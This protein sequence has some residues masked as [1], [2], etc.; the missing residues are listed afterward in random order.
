L[1]QIE[2]KAKS[3]YIDAVNKKKSDPAQAK[4]IAQTIVVMLPESAETHQKAKQLLQE[5]GP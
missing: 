2:G 3:L 5:L 4:R 1:E